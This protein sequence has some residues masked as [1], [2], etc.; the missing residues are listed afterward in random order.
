MSFIKRALEVEFQ[1]AT[2]SFGQDLGDTVAVAGMRT[3]ADIV[4]YA[5]VDFQGTLALR[6]EGLPLAVINQ[7]TT[8]GTVAQEKRNNLVRVKASDE[9]GG[10]SLVYSG[11]IFTAFGEFNGAPNVMFS[12]TAYAAQTAAVLPVP[13]VSFKGTIDCATVLEGFAKAAG[14]TFVNNGVSVQ[15]SN[16]Y[17]AGSTLDKIKKCVEMAH[18]GASISL[19]TLT[20]WPRGGSA[21]SATEIIISPETGMIGYPTFSPQGIALSTLY[22]PNVQVGNEI[23]VQSALPVACGKWVV[24][25]IYHRLQSE[26]P[27]GAWF[28]Q[29][30][31]SS[32][33]A[34]STS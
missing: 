1:L 15:L 31:A 30:E 34:R 11:Q 32:P 9:S 4:S 33:Y 12:V 27:N 10:M 23:T 2:G 13:A 16:P 18:I 21:A 20:I 19:N 29:I 17:F 6:I 3:S 24:Y 25:G 22:N 5:G 28:T 7:L 8:I 14:M 26:T